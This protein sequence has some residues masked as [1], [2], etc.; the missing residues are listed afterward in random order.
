M[1]FSIISISAFVAILNQCV[2]YIADTFIKKDISKYIPIFSGVFGIILG[3]AGYYISNV[4]MGNNIIEA[5]F[6][7]LCAGLSSTGAHQIGK[8]LNKDSNTD[9]ESDTSNPVLEVF[10]NIVSNT[11]VDNTY[12]EESDTSSSTDTDDVDDDTDNNDVDVD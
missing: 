2:K 5:F 4:D 8:Q 12:N 7:G 10:Q 1:E 3:I 11:N 6:I 9:T